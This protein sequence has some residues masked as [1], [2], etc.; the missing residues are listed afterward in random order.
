MVESRGIMDKFK[1]YAYR[2]S[3]VAVAYI[4]ITLVLKLSLQL[5][6]NITW[7]GATVIMLVACVFTFISWRKKENDIKFLVYI[8]AVLTFF[9][10]YITF[11]YYTFKFYYPADQGTVYE[12]QVPVTSEDGKYT[13]TAY[14]RE[15]DG[16]DSDRKMWI[17]V[18]DHT[19]EE[20]T[21]VYFSDG[22]DGFQMQFKEDHELVVSYNDDGVATQM[23]LTIGEDIY[24]ETGSACGTPF[25]KRNYIN[26]YSDEN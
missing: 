11:S 20:E 25:A 2:T 16:G 21:T 17:N 23:S 5:E 14:Y 10:A 19:T 24:D 12:E 26:C 3:L 15:F 9:S 13:A 22:R 1:K 6:I 18:I 8:V 7:Q 4:I